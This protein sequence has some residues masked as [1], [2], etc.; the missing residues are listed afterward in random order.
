MVRLEA[1]RVAGKGRLEGDAWASIQGKAVFGIADG[2]ARARCSSVFALVT[3][4]QVVEI[5]VFPRRRRS[6]PDR[7]R[8]GCSEV[9]GC[10]GNCRR[11]RD[12]G[13]ASED[14]GS[15]GAIGGLDRGR[16]A[17]RFAAA[18]DDENPRVGRSRAVMSLCLSQIGVGGPRLG[19]PRYGR[20]SRPRLRRR[21]GRGA[22]SIKAGMFT[23][24][25]PSARDPSSIVEGA[26][27]EEQSSAPPRPRAG[28]A[29]AGRRC[30]GCR[31]NLAVGLVSAVDVRT[32]PRLISA[33]DR[34]HL[35]ISDG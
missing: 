6:G 23:P 3:A 27:D 20:A 31:G 24:R 15:Q 11:G 34:G 19:R 32:G 18:D 4:D 10:G 1:E 12:F 2:H 13:A 5:L 30:A 29:V 25:R 17:R 35:S 9:C 21:R 14:E 8:G 33:F 22:A 28:E 7:G 16:K 26:E